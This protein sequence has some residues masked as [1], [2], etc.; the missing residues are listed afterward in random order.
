MHKKA[1]VEAPFKNIAEAGGEARVHKLI[2]THLL[3][4]EFKFQKHRS[5]I[6]GENE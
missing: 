6:C 2:C 3:E 5:I 4:E 1:Y